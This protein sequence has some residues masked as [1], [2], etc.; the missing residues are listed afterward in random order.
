MVFF[1]KKTETGTFAVKNNIRN[2]ATA[3]EEFWLTLLAVLNAQQKG[4]M[5][6][7]KLF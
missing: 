7:L 4:C 6:M 1:R 2:F 3:K 5:M